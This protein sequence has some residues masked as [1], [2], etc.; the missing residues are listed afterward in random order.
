MTMKT[1]LNGASWNKKIE[2]L[3]I[4]KGWTQKEAAEKCGAAPKAYWE[5]EKGNRHPRLNNRRAIAKAFGVSEKEI[6]N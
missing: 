4:A 5:W 2:L 1:M 6:F 3:R